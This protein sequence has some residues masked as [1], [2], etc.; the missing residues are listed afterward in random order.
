MEAKINYALATL[1]GKTFT[2][3]QLMLAFESQGMHRVHAG[4][5]CNYVWNVGLVK[6]RGKGENQVG[7]VV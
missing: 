3:E 5:A 2:A 1:K 4:L 6:W 7:C